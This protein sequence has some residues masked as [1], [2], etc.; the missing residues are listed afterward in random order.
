M[1]THHR[2]CLSCRKLAPKPEFIRVVRLHPSHEI[3]IDTGM[4]RSAYLCPNLNCIQAAQKKD[5]LSRA[6]KASVPPQVY[7]SLKQRQ[8]EFHSPIQPELY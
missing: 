5:R 7:Q 8:A 4:G 3:S 6:L 1:P 2:R